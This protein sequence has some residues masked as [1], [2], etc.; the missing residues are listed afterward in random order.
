MPRYSIDI[1]NNDL[2]KI[3]EA[4]T[5]SFVFNVKDSIDETQV[6]TEFEFWKTKWQRTKT[7]GI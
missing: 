6:Q 3:T 7:D 1:S 4:A 2:K 5:T